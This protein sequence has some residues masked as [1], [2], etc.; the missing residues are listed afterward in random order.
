MRLTRRRL[1]QGLGLGLVGAPLLARANRP[2][3][4]PWGEARIPRRWATG[5]QHLAP[6]AQIG[7]RILFAG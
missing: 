1:L 2:W 6:A 4:P 3:L 5:N 7:G